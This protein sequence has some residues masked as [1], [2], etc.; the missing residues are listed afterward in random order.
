MYTNANGG[1]MNT[2]GPQP[3]QRIHARDEQHG[4]PHDTHRR[5]HIQAAPHDSL[6]QRPIEQFVLPGLQLQVLGIGRKHK[7]HH[8]TPI[9]I[10]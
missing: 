4:E 3:R 9:L 7:R 8:A 2:A 10:K 1:T 5:P 6:S